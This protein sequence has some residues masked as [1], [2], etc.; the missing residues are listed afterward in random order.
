[1]PVDG[2]TVTSTW[3]DGYCTPQYGCFGRHFFRR[4]FPRDA[5]GTVFEHIIIFD[6][7]KEL[8]SSSPD[9]IARELRRFKVPKLGALQRRTSPVPASGSRS[10]CHAAN[11]DKAA[12]WPPLDS[13][14]STH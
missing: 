3:D 8:V 13:E 9:L 12:P 6:S 1:M 11:L 4:L 7:R 10:L 2:S 14:T 5:G